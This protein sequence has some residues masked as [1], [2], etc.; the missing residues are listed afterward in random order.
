MSV[1]CPRCREPIQQDWDL[2]HRCGLTVAE[3]ERLVHAAN[4]ALRSGEAGAAASES[5]AP[6]AS[7][8]YYAEP[9]YGEGP[10]RRST[11]YAPPSPRVNDPRRPDTVIDLTGGEAM[12]V[13]TG[14]GAA[15]PAPA[16][17]RPPVQHE[18]RRVSRRHN[19]ELGLTMALAVAVIFV[20]IVVFL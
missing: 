20:V 17:P 7:P 2:C 9:V 13:V 8:A 16:P 6:D 10:V 12:I 19:I 15:T 1:S 14:S 4:P 11:G 18:H 3:L 5:P